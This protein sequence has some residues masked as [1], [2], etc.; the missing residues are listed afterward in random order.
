MESSTSMV[1]IL[2]TSTEEWYTALQMPIPMCKMS[3]T[4]IGNMWYLVGGFCVSSA[5]KVLCVSL[6]NLITQ[7]I[8]SSL[9]ASTMEKP[10]L[11]LPDAP[12]VKCVAFATK[13]ALIAIGGSTLLL[14]KHSLK[15]WILIGKMP[16]KQC[17]CTCCAVLPSGEVFMVSGDSRHVDICTLLQ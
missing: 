16:N 2:N 5:T 6:D 17:N 15:R 7:T 12:L 10:W 9:D 8:V 1:E 14:Y 3:S 4:V 11:L 13:G